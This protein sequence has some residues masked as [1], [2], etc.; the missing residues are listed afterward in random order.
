MSTVTEMSYSFVANH[1]IYNEV[2]K[3][4]KRNLFEHTLEKLA[5]LAAY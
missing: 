3:T 5:F 4:F 1:C 2:Q